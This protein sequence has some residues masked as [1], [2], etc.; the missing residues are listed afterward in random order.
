MSVR[1]SVSA[2]VAVCTGAAILVPVLSAQTLAAKPRVIEVIADKDNR[3]KVPGESK[4]VITLKAGE[5]VVLRITSHF[6]GE[7][8]RDGSVHSFAV[9]KLREQGWDLRLHEGTEDFT[10]LAPTS[11]GEYEVECTVK[12]GPGHDDMKMKLIVQG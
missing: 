12:C 2:L 5:K 8:A 6:G 4:P 7:K 9:K 1:K 10:L 11:P 3:F